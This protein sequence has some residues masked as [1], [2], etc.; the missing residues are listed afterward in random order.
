MADATEQYRRL[1]LIARRTKY[2]PATELKPV[3][4]SVLA[5]FA[6][7][8]PVL[9]PRD[10]GNNPGG[11]LQLPPLP[12]VIVPDLH[13]RVDYLSLLARWT[14]PGMERPVLEALA[15]GELQVICVGDGFHAE[16]RALNRWKSSLGEFAGLYKKHAAMDEEMNESL[17]VMQIVM[18]WKTAFPG[19]F[20]FLKG[21]HENIANE[22]SDDNRPFR[23]FAWEGEMVSYWFKKFL[24]DEVYSLWYA[25]EK[26]L[27]VFAAGDR[28][29]VCHAEPR[30]H[31]PRQDLIDSLIRREI[32]FDLTWTDD[33]AAEEGSVDAT[34][35]EYFPGRSEARLFGGHRPV[36][37]NYNLRAGGRYI[38]IHN[39]A[40]KIAAFV[41]DMN[42]FTPE[43]GITELL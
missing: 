8:D 24:G 17:S 33:D 22:N 36:G 38:Q 34:L 6:A 9:R 14:P 3:L 27:P 28:F 20:H 41:R 1:D 30:V 21:N 16:K 43:N 23:K 2:P 10:S 18:E 7:E 31:Y 19:F 12:T 5:T 13:A 15:A 40:K 29:C 4:S 35:E 37:G 11:F 39:P 26:R 25:F 42:D 32:V